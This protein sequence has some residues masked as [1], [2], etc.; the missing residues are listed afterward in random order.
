MSEMYL[1]FKDICMH[2]KSFESR[3]NLIFDIDLK[4]VCV[5]YQ[6]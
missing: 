5:N 3:N 2:K 6:R 1:F 4:N